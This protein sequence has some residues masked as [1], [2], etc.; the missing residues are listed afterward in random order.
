MA[1]NIGRCDI[2]ESGRDSDCG[3]TA[4]G[5]AFSDAGETGSFG[6]GVVIQAVV[7][8]INVSIGA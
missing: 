6:F 4:L 7:K 2:G 3:E 5:F 8:F 1:G